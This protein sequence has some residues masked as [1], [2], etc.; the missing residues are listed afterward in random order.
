[1]HLLQFTTVKLSFCLIVGV[2]T[3]N[4]LRISLGLSIVLCLFLLFILGLE[5]RFGQKTPSSRFGLLTALLTLAIGNL[6][7]TFTQPTN[8]PDHYSHFST[9]K[10]QLYILKI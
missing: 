6:S 10:N 7:I 4:L 3:G 2:L 1:M 8:K 9:H 5:H